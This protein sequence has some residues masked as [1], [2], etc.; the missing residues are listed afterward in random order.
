VEEPVADR[1]QVVE[2]EQRRRG[3]EPVVTMVAELG[4]SDVVGQV[5]RQGIVR[6]DGI[7]E[8]QI[9]VVAQIGKAEYLDLET[10]EEPVEYAR[11]VVQNALRLAEM[12]GEGQVRIVLGRQVNLISMAMVMQLVNPEIAPEVWEKFLFTT[13]NMVDKVYRDVKLS[14]LM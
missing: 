4:T 5:E 10:L 14:D 3:L 12:A 8:E 7:R 9:E 2:E 6:R 13:F 1:V 11:L